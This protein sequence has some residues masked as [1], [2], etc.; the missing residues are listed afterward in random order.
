MPFPLGHV[1]REAHVQARDV[2]LHGYLEDLRVHGR[3]SGRW[4]SGMGEP[5]DMNPWSPCQGLGVG[6]GKGNHGWE[7]RDASSLFPKPQ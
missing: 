1:V 5:Q 4:D 7:W 3:G 6:S 2:A